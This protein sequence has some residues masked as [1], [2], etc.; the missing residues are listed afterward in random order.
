VNAVGLRSAMMPML[1][2]VKPYSSATACVIWCTAGYLAFMVASSSQASLL[3]QR[4][5]K[6]VIQG[7][8]SHITVLM[9]IVSVIASER[10][11]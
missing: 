8:T 11:T 4:S 6:S 9:T 7:L 5:E 2:A 3:N 10:S 1:G